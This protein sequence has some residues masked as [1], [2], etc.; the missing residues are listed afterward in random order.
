MSFESFIKE[1]KR[2]FYFLMWDFTIIFFHFLKPVH[3]LNTI[4]NII[5]TNNLVGIDGLANRVLNTEPLEM[6]SPILVIRGVAHSSYL[7]QFVSTH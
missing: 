5:L 1:R 2:K 4:E 7:S 3:V 6:A